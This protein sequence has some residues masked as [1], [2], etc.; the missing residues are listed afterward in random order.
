MMKEVRWELVAFVITIV[1]LIAV[2]VEAFDRGFYYSGGS[3]IACMLLASIPIILRRYRVIT[4]PLWMALW[5]L[6][7]LWLH[8]YGI[9]HDFYGRIYWFDELTHTM[10]IGL[11]A[12]AIFLLLI[13]LNHHSKHV[14][15]P[16][17]TFPL[18]MIIFAMG[19]GVTWEVMEFIL[20]VTVNTPMQY[21]LTDSVSDMMTDLGGGLL[22]SAFC[23]VYLL[24]LS[25]EEVSNTLNAD[26]LIRRYQRKYHHGPRK[27]QRDL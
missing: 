18:F 21:S 7:L 23:L 15:L 6:F 16:S 19:L 14:R 13:L 9:L 26:R 10:A 22:A 8:S 1:L 11:A 3:A 20:D 25:P 27:D 5:Y 24:F 12:C 2:A 4:F 17:L